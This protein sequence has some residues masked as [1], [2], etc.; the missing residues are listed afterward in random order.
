M[1][2]YS[3]TSV[4]WHATRIIKLPVFPAFLLFVLP[5][6]S[7]FICFFSFIFWIL[8][9]FIRSLFVSLFYFCLFSITIF[10]L[11]C[12]SPRSSVLSG[13][14]VLLFAFIF[15]VSLWLFSF[16]STC[17]DSFPVGLF[18][19]CLLLSFIFCKGLKQNKIKQKTNKEKHFGKH[20]AF[21]IGLA[22]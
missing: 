16:K 5:L 9:I 18:L 21:H 10:L 19:R 14:I 2:P 4:T 15:F 6:L 12:F 7:F 17:S 22:Q 20:L 11:V 8:L 3:C 13:T 1:C